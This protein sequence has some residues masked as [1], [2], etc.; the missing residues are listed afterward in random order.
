[1]GFLRMLLP[2]NG[3]HMW[4]IDHLRITSKIHLSAEER[5]RVTLSPTFMFLSKPLGL[6]QRNTEARLD[7]SMGVCWRDTEARLDPSVGVSCQ[8]IDQVRSFYGS[9]LQSTLSRI[10]GRPPC[11][12]HHRDILS[13]PNAGVFMLGSSLNFQ[14]LAHSTLVSLLALFL[15]HRADALVLCD[16]WVPC[17]VLFFISSSGAKLAPRGWSEQ[18]SQRHPLDCYG[19]FL[20]SLPSTTNQATTLTLHMGTNRILHYISLFI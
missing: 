16:L 20:W 12:Y 11:G 5:E 8:N 3:S 6:L 14:R 18:P 9:L 19:P 7:S 2:L 15:G 13:S 4:L 17:F 1:M 10:P